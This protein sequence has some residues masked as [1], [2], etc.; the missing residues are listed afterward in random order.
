MDFPQGLVPALLDYLNIHRPLLVA[1][2]L[3]DRLWIS[4]WGRPISSHALGFRISAA[5][6]RTIGIRVTPHLFRDAAATTIATV[7]PAHVRMITPL[8]GHATP[9]TAEKYYNH[10][11][12]LEASRAHQTNIRELR[13]ETR[14]IGRRTIPADRR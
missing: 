9:V 10:A 11:S 3:S 7:D 1:G 6:Q 2:R 8:L 5:L 12:S 4:R 14:P 13:E